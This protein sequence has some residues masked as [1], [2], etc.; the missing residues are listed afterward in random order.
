M[1]NENNWRFLM[2]LDT[3]MLNFLSDKV[4]KNFR[5]YFDWELKT[6]R[7]DWYSPKGVNLHATGIP[8]RHCLMNAINFLEGYSE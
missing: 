5:L 2:G 3:E 4:G 8:L 1:K 6:Y 7:I